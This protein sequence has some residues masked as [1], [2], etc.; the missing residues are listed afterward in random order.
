MK[1][2]MMA[3]GQNGVRLEIVR[4]RVEFAKEHAKEIVIPPS[5]LKEAYHVLDLIQKPNIVIQKHV[6]VGS[7]GNVKTM[8]R[9]SDLFDNMICL[10]TISKHNHL[11]F[12]YNQSFLSLLQHLIS[13]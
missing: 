5:H 8:T 2:K 9:Y 4:S 13:T 10:E 7:F 3:V 12:F 11:L 1:M 6:M